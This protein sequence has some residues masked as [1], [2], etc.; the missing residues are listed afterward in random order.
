MYVFVCVCTIFFFD[1]KSR[2]TYNCL[3]LDLVNKEIWKINIDRESV[4]FKERGNDSIGPN[5]SRIRLC[6]IIHTFLK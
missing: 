3:Y 6:L 4:S 2:Y 5:I 1:T